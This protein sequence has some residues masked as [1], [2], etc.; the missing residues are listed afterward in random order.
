[1]PTRRITDM[2]ATKTFEIT[3]RRVDR[4]PGGAELAG[5]LR[6]AMPDGGYAVD[7]ALR[8][9]FKRESAEE[10]RAALAPGAGGRG[11]A[12]WARCWSRARAAASA[13]SVYVQCAA[14]ANG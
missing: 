8:A 7:R 14:H 4:S 5:A 9:A 11:A 6:Q 10:M 3:I 2:G 1:M 13:S 12:R